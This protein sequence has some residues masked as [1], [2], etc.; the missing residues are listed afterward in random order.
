MKTNMRKHRVAVLA[1][2]LTAVGAAPALADCLEDAR[3]VALAQ[4]SVARM[5]SYI[6]QLGNNVSVRVSFTASPTWLR[7]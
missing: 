1:P 5:R 3:E 6:C 7:A 4:D 2:F